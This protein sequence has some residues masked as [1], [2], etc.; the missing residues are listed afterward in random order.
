M[1]WKKMKCVGLVVALAG[2]GGGG[3]SPTD[4]MPTPTPAPNCPISI[5]SGTF[6]RGSFNEC[7]IRVVL[8]NRTAENLGD[9]LMG[10]DA[11][12]SSGIQIATAGCSGRLFANNSVTLDC[13]FIDNASALF[14]DCSQIAYATDTGIGNIINHP[15]CPP[16]GMRFMP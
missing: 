13:G 5:V 4:P 16:S 7:R 12:N 14:R 15:R 2:C 9:V 1:Q 6:G 11:Y 8:Q 3:D 10:V